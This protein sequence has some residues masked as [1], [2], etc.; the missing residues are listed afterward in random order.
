MIFL[1]IFSGI[2]LN[3]DILS[4]SETKQNVMNMGNRCVGKKGG[5]Q[6]LEE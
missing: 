2:V 4:G 6:R 1:T 5:Q 3:C